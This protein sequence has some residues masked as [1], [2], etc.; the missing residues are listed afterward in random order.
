MGPLD[1]LTHLINFLA[2]AFGLATLTAA[3]AKLAWR[4]ELRRVAWGRLIGWG[5]SAG[6]VALVAGLV[7]FGR[8]GKVATYGAMVLLNALAQWWAGFG[9]RP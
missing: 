9:S 4:V 6:L 7:V 2:P 3:L 8:D 1:A 5:A